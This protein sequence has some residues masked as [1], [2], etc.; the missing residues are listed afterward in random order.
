MEQA[1]LLNWQV[2]LWLRTKQSDDPLLYGDTEVFSGNPTF[3]GGGKSRNE[4]ERGDRS[5]P[6]DHFRAEPCNGSRF[7]P[8]LLEENQDRI[9]VVNCGPGGV[10][11]K[12]EFSDQRGHIEDVRERGE[13]DDEEAEAE[14]TEEHRGGHLG[15]GVE[16]LAE[17]R[18]AAMIVV[19]RKT[20]VKN[21]DCAKEEWDEP[22]QK[23]CWGRWKDGRLTPE[24]LHENESAIL[25]DKI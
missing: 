9:V 2:E 3:L 11:Q 25:N 7:R 13:E 19:K 15:S 5:H 17:E 8:V 12:A 23:Q 16:M 21:G 22:G 18:A 24:F 10:I 20:G 4:R 1:N 6:P 14:E